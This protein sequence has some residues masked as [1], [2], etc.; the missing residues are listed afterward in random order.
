MHGYGEGF[1]IGPTTPPYNPTLYVTENKDELYKSQLEV[2]KRGV[3]SED[4]K[5]VDKNF[6]NAAGEEIIRLKGDNENFFP[7][8]Y[9]IP[10]DEKNQKNILEAFKEGSA[11]FEISCVSNKQPKI[12]T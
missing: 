3:D 2:F 10:K 8:Y 11:F 4:N 5:A 7:D 6:T 12:Q 9:V 1:L